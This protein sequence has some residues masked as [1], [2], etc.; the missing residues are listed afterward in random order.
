METKVLLCSSFLQPRN[1]FL[2]VGNEFWKQICHEHGIQQDGTLDPTAA[3]R[4]G[5][6]DIFFYQSD[7]SHYIPRAIMIDLEPRVP[8]FLLAAR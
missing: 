1:L 6:E 5:Q 2:L 3:V 8:L 7:N 4:D